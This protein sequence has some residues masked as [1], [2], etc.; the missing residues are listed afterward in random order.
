M[1]NILGLSYYV[2]SHPMFSMDMK[3]I[4]KCLLPQIKCRSITQDNCHFSEFSVKIELYFVTKT[5]DCV[6]IQF[7]NVVLALECNECVCLVCICALNVHCVGKSLVFPDFVMWPQAKLYNFVLQIHIEWGRPLLFLCVSVGKCKV[8][9][10]Y[11]PV[12]IV[13]HSFFENFNRYTLKSWNFVFGLDFRC[14][15]QTMPNTLNYFFS[16]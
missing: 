14:S 3:T 13:L 6:F 5:C 9:I 15:R 11:S 2:F 16:V 10:I 1:S 7:L 4:V 12:W 8:V